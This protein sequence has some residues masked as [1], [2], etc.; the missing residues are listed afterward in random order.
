MALGFVSD[1][2]KNTRLNSYKYPLKN[3]EDELI[4]QLDKITQK[5]IL[6]VF[7]RNGIN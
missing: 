1:F 5:P 4:I 3:Q 2:Q 6:L 7:K